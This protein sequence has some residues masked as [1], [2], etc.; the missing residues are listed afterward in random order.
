MEAIE[1][2][3]FEVEFSFTFWILL[4]Q[5]LL[6]LYARQ[7]NQTSICSW[8][9]REPC[10]RPQLIHKLQLEIN[11]IFKVSIS[12]NSSSTG[13]NSSL[14]LFEL[15]GYSHPLG[16]SDAGGSYHGIDAPEIQ[17]GQCL[18]AQLWWDSSYFPGGGVLDR[19]QR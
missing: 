12:I 15:S 3:W 4:I 13:K 8:V 17:R 10:L 16:M 9:E 1:K 2:L 18:H 6:Y 14:K 5:S 11:F 19:M 7:T